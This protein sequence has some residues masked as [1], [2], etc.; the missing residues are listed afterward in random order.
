MIMITPAEFEDE[1]GRISQNEEIE[2]RHKAA[3]E[4]MCKV[5]QE[6]GYSSGV[7]I[8][9]SMKKWYA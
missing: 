4:L 1:M 6:N 2:L 5:L 7:K 8:F 3:D 9:E